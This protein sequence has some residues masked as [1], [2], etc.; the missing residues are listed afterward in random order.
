MRYFVAVA[1]LAVVGCGGFTPPSSVE[2]DKALT[3]TWEQT[4][5]LEKK[6]RPMLRWLSPN[7]CEPSPGSKAASVCVES[8]VSDDDDTK[9]ATVTTVWRGSFSDSQFA[10][11]LEMLR[12]RYLTGAYPVQENA[13]IVTAANAALSAA[14]L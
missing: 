1:M 5:Q 6:S 9:P 10:A 3:I 13:D 14:G 12:E 2:E 7:S 11:G 4:L 8:E